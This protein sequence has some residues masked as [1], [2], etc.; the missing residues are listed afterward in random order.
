MNLSPNAIG[1]IKRNIDGSE[2]ATAISK[3]GKTIEFKM[4]FKVKG[5]SAQDVLDLC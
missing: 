4:K 2:Y 3:D 1:A 5:Y